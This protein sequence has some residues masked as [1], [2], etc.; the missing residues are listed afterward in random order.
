MNNVVQR[1]SNERVNFLVPRDL[2]KKAEMVAEEYDSS[3]S[4]LFRQALTIIIQQYEQERKAKAIAEACTYYYKIDKKIA[5]E[6]ESADS[7]V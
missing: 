4:D 7:K 3:L 5:A 6:W 2:L 1:G